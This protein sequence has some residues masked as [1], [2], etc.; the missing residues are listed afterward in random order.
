MNTSKKEQLGAY[1]ENIVYNEL[2][3]RGY[4]VIIGI[5]ENLIMCKIITKNM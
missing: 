1:V 2:V 3:Y 4:D 5:L